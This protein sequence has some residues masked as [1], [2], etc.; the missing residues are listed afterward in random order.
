MQNSEE[1]IECKVVDIDEKGRGICIWKGKHIRVEGALPGDIAQFQP[2]RGFR[3]AKTL[4]RGNYAI[5]PSCVHFGIC[6]GCSWQ[7]VPY[8]QQVWH[9]ERML[10]R[11]LDKVLTSKSK[12]YPILP[13][14]RI[15]YYRNKLEFTFSHTRW[16][17]R[18][19]IDSEDRVID[20]RA[21][22]FFVRK[23][24]DRVVDINSCHL[25]ESNDIRN[26]IKKYA[27]T[28]DVPFYS[29][30][31]RTGILRN[32]LIRSN[33]SEQFMVVLIFAVYDK[34]LAMKM[35]EH[36]CK[37]FP[38]IVSFQLIVND[39][40]NDSYSQYPAETL[41]GSQYIVEHCD[42]ITIRIYPQSF[43]QTNSYQAMHLYRLIASWLKE[44]VVTCVYDLYCG[45]GSIGLYILNDSNQVIGI[46][47]VSMAVQA[48]WEN[49]RDISAKNIS[50]FVG[51]VED[52]LDLDF[53]TTHGFPDAVILDPPRAG[54]HDR[55]IDFLKKIRP[56]YIYYVSCNP[57]SFARNVQ[58]LSEYYEIRQLRAVDMF[59]HTPHIEVV[60]EL[61]RLNV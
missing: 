9:K 41:F 15:Y 37:K 36:I 33:V 25:Q 28:Y 23:R 59:P 40:L 18:N 47:S 4:K 27:L 7:H 29:S 42:H 49:A 35:G 5:K 51:K 16:L 53:A 55:T 24:F 45:A 3:K 39:S 22:G 61:C 12:V 52:I 56:A 34:Q 2:G 60:A 11:I 46:E 50:F 30:Q 20:R 44:R 17:S 26:E 19:D 14:T 43:Y 58:Q 31:T 54:V 48:A 21:L 32:V 8:V 10:A 6:G 57:I 38:Q 1:I 13:A